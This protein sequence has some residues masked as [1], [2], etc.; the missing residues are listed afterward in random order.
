MSRA[1]S[2]AQ[3]AMAVATTFVPD[4]WPR[5]RQPTRP[6]PSRHLIYGVTAGDDL[7]NDAGELW[8]VVG[9]VNEIK[10]GIAIRGQL[11]VVDAES[12]CRA[13]TE[14]RLRRLREGLGRLI[15]HITAGEAVH[16]H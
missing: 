14:Q 6:P 2:I 7:G 10:H 15:Q 12:L 5:L 16:G 11:R 8:R 13:L 4:P 1:T 9:Q 3:P